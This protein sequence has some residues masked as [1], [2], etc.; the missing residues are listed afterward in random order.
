LASKQRY[1]NAHPDKDVSY[2]AKNG[3]HIRQK[4]R[5]RNAQDP[6]SNR[7]RVKRWRK[8]HPL[9]RSVQRARRRARKLGASGTCSAAQLR[10]RIALYGGLCWVPGCG[11]AYEAID[12]V[13][14][15]AKGGSNWPSNLRPICTYHNSQK[16]TRSWAEFA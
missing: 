4:M 11:K 9:E 14:P 13:I 2:Y 5:N 15:L 8:E 12:H 1:K 16:H 6:E 7:S 10:A 3:E